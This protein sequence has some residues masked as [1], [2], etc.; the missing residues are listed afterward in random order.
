MELPTLAPVPNI[1]KEPLT[2]KATTSGITFLKENIFRSRYTGNKHYAVDCNGNLWTKKDFMKYIQQTNKRFG[3][4]AKKKP[5]HPCNGGTKTLEIMP[6][7]SN[8]LST[9]TNT[10]HTNPAKLSTINKEYS[11]NKREVRQRLLGYI[12]TMRGKKELYFFTVTF[13]P[14]IVDTVAYQAF[15]IWLTALRQRNML[16]EY[17]WIAERQQTGTIHFHI[18]IPHYMHVHKANAMMRG[19][20]KNMIRKGKIDYSIYKIARYNGVDIAKNRNT[21][22]VTNFAIKKGTR[23]LVTYLTKYVTK[24]DTKFAHLAWHNSRG[25]SMLFTGVTFNVPE[26]ISKGFHLLINRAKAFVG[27]FFIHIPWLNDPPPLL[28][29]HLY[30]INSH[31]QSLLN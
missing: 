18:A 29:E 17:I 20:L 19:T 5:L 23:S 13:P 30:K 25:F 28:V 12:N 3:L 21:K 16:K 11:V 4:Q 24:N 26:F 27:E 15:N 1:S 7:I 31:L 10:L 9:E 6:Q 8:N 2:I 14:G 22:R